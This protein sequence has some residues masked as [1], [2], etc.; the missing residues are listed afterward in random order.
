MT[1]PYRLSE[2]NAS[3]Y[4]CIE[5]TDQ[6]IGA[7]GRRASGSS[8]LE[9]DD[10]VNTRL[11]NPGKPSRSQMLAKLHT[12][13]GWGHRLFSREVC[14]VEADAGLHHQ[15]LLAIGLRKV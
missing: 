12:E 3:P 5:L 9:L 11:S 8:E 14:Q 6:V 7:C 15:V 4:R 2:N 1:L 10:S 13:L